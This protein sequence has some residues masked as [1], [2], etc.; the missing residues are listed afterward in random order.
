MFYYSNPSYAI[1]YAVL[2][3]VLLVLFPEP[4]YKGPENVTYFRGPNLKEEIDRDKRI[5]WV[6]QFFAGWSPLCRQ[7]TPVFAQLSNEY[8]LKNLRFAKMD[9]SRYPKEAEKFRI[10]IHPTSR[11]LPTV[12]LFQNGKEVKRRPTIDSNHRAV[13]YVFKKENI[14]FDFDLNTIYAECKANLSK[15]DLETVETQKKTN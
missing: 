2:A 10:N 5:V 14:I 3:I 7:V 4:A 1:I 15:K 8:A 12:S 6:V 13:P 11:Q 9:I